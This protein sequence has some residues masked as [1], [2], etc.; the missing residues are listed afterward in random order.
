MTSCIHSSFT[1]LDLHKKE[2]HVLYRFPNNIVIIN[3]VCYE[4][5]DLARR[6]VL[7]NILFQ[8]GIPLKL[9]RLKIMCL[10]E[11][12]SRVRVGKHW[13]DMFPIKKSSKQGDA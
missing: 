10:N 3:A 2:R 6:E 1:F 7:Y 13:S 8:V 4:A 5:L 12:Y 9:V 11:T